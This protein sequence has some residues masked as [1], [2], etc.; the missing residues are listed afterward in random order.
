VNLPRLLYPLEDD[1][2]LVVRDPRVELVDTRV[3]KVALSDLEFQGR[4]ETDGRAALFGLELLRGGIKGHS[5]RLNA[6]EAVLYLPSRIAH[7]AHDFDLELLE[8]ELLL[9]LCDFALRIARLF[10]RSVLSGSPP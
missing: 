4:R 10:G 9:A 5:R 1:E 2:R 6:L 7:F 8:A 3:R